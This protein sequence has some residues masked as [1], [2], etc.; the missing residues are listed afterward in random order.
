MRRRP[1]AVWKRPTPLWK[2][3]LIFAANVIGFAALM[4]LLM[5]ALVAAPHIDAWVINSRP[6]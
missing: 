3:A 2:T 6:W 4:G 1:M 5:L